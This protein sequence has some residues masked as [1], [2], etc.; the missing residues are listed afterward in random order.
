MFDEEKYLECKKSWR[1]WVQ[2]NGL[3]KCPICGEEYTK[4]GVNYHLRHHFGYV[5]PSPSFLNKKHTEVTKKK[6]S[7]SMKKA[8]K[9]GRAYNI[10]CNMHKGESS[11]PEKFFMKII[12]NN[13]DDKNYTSQYQFSKYKLDFAWSH[14]LK[15]IE[16]DGQQHYRNN[17]NIIHDNIRDK[18]LNQNG[19]EGIRI[20]WPDL[21]NNTDAVIR[22]A[23]D[24]IDSDINTFKYE[25]NLAKYELY[26]KRKN[27]IKKNKS[28]IEY[29]KKYIIDNDINFNTDDYETI[30]ANIINTKY[31]VLTW[32]NKYCQELLPSNLQ[33]KLTKKQIVK[34][35][36][37]EFI[38]NR[39]ELIKNANIDF[40]K[41][42][43]SIL[44]AR[45][46]NIKNAHKAKIFTIEYCSDILPDNYYVK[47]I[48]TRNR[49]TKEEKTQLFVNDRIK[50]IK[51]S[52]IIIGS[53]GWR[54]KLA[55]I[56]HTNRRNIE[57]W[58]RE[59]A[60]YLLS[61]K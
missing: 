1:T 37:K 21:F 14:L 17:N 33:Q 30:L 20:F 8:H 57:K 23:K 50:K 4:H 47:D 44:V 34:Q 39:I 16:I 29:I 51:N 58:I 9:E 36:Q 24:F 48:N 45:L 18:F 7:E 54:S 15:Y 49:L 11:Y 22:L 59:N 5:N 38:N 13:F 46:I 60:S 35:K 10:G 28:K 6:V 42:G 32:L 56:L 3:Y 27:E 52:G 19:W 31:S 61:N 12:E 41:R 55:K 43:W 40:T 26:I 2:N 53:Y 25:D